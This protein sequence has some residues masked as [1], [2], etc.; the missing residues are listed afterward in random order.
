MLEEGEV[1]LVSI[2]LE[3]AVL[4]LGTLEDEA[5]GAL[6]ELDEVGAH[7]ELEA[8]PLKGLMDDEDEVEP[9]VV[10]ALDELDDVGAHDE[11]EAE[12]LGATLDDDEVEPVAFD[13]ELLDDVVAAFEEELAEREVK[14][15]GFM[16]PQSHEDEGEV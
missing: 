4:P 8:E 16:E 14:V 11:L 12:P 10:G 1:V 2:E 5:V 3:L 15:I 13:T 9:V 6:E 7:D